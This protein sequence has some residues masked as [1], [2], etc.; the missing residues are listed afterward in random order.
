LTGLRFFAA[1][2]IVWLHLYGFG[3]VTGPEYP[4]GIGVSLFFIL[5]GFILAH[6]YQD[7]S[8]SSFAVFFRA[9]IAK[10]YPLHI[11]TLV[12][13]LLLVPTRYSPGGASE[14]YGILLTNAALLQSWIPST[15]VIFSFNGPSWSLSNELFFYFCF[16]FIMMVRRFVI[17]IFL[18][19]MALFAALIVLAGMR[20]EMMEPMTWRNVL[21]FNP[22][23]RI[24]EFVAG[25][26]I[27]EYMY[28]AVRDARFKRVTVSA[29]QMVAAVFF[30]FGIPWLLSLLTDVMAGSRF[31]EGGSGELLDMWL[32]LTGGVLP[33][34]FLIFAFSLP[35]GVLGWVVSRQPFK[36]LGEISFATYMIHHILLRYFVSAGLW[37][38]Q[39]S[40]IT[41]V[42]YL[43]ATYAGSYVLWKFVEIPMQRLIRGLPRKGR[44]KKYALPNGVAGVAPYLVTAVLGIY[45]Y[46]AYSHQSALIMARDQRYVYDNGMDV[47]LTSSSRCEEGICITLEWHRSER[48]KRPMRRVLQ[49]LNESRK[50]VVELEHA[51]GGEGYGVCVTDK[52]VDEIVVPGDKLDKA[53]Y[54]RLGL[55]EFDAR[56]VAF[57]YDG[58][59]YKKWMMVQKILQ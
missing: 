8:L 33:G 5:S 7:I 34:A 46:S 3:I 23:F 32:E 58:E 42:L 38:E 55:K 28:K 56:F 57:E 13:V 16:P 45:I 18:V 52:Y 43:A 37:S 14:D 50:P 31:F 2:M 1:A 41:T 24:G 59:K 22:F 44:A 40:A 11:A 39:A 6:N 19:W 35:N 49:V 4:L 20:P 12:I 25:I 21:Q 47:M 48:C 51:L 17:G 15:D 10:I 36:L 29:L 30:A 9:R 27:Y 53:A 26:I 54:L